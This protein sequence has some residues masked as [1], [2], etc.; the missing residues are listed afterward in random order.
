VPLGH[1]GFLTFVLDLDESED[2]LDLDLDLDFDFD[3]DLD[4]DLD[5]DLDL[6]LDLDSA[7]ITGL[8]AFSLGAGRIINAVIS[9]S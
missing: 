6:D 2:D 1:L 3:L 9:G 8:S 7:N 4:L 5:S